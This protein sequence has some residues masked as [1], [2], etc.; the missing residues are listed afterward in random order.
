MAIQLSG[1]RKQT[2]TTRGDHY[3]VTQIIHAFAD[4]YFTGARAASRST[5]NY[6]VLAARY[7]N[8]CLEQNVPLLFGIT[9]YKELVR[10]S[11]ISPVNRFLVFYQERG[12]PPVIVDPPK[13]KGAP[14][15]N[16]LVLQFIY[17]AGSLRGD[18]SKATYQKSLNAFFDW[19]EGKRASGHTLIGFDAVGIEQF[20]AEMRQR[21]YSAFTINLRLSALKALARFVLEN[22]RKFP[23]DDDQ[24]EGLAAIEKVNTLSLEQIVYK[25]ALSVED[26]DK[27]LSDCDDPETKAMIS[28]MVYSGLRTVELTRLQVQDLDMQTGIVYVLG[29]GKYMREAVKLFRH[30][31][32]AVQ[33]LIRQ[34]PDRQ[35]KGFL[36]P[37]LSTRK[38]RRLVDAA[39]AVSGLKRQGIS[40]HSLRHTAAQLLLEKGVDGIYVQ[41]HLR[42]AR[43]ETTQ[44]YTRKKS[45]ELYLN[46]LPDD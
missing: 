33:E 45:R 28:L 1:R 26:R 46:K 27:L 16:E 39:L 40:A 21:H 9:T 15:G 44:M 19:L 32:E 3:T 17:Q 30:S 13:E 6:P 38:I 22:P 2:I 20:M 18:E 11:Y 29:K 12:C 36:F 37:D 35:G 23:L 7:V 31:I 5:S 8:Y 42:H 4:W 10:K 25:D 24:W 41:H 43:F 34:R 14:A